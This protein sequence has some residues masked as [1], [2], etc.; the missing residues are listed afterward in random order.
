MDPAPSCGWDRLSDFP[1]N[2]VNL[3]NPSLG[4]RIS[5]GEH[6]TAV[7]AALAAQATQ[8]ASLPAGTGHCPT[9][10]ASSKLLVHPEN[11]GKVRNP[12]SKPPGISQGPRS[13]LPGAAQE[14]QEATAEQALAIQASTEE[15]AALVQPETHGK[16]RNSASGTTGIAQGPRTHVPGAAQ[17]AQA[18]VAEQ[19][20]Q[21]ARAAKADQ[22][23]CAAQAA[24]EVRT[25]QPSGTS[26]GPRDQLAVAAQEA[27]EAEQAASAA[28]AAL[29]MC[30]AARTAKADQVE[31]TARAAQE[32]RALKPSGTSEGPRYQLA[33]AA[34]ETIEAE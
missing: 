34:Q 31:S 9:M 23:E 24:Q 10:K 5:S 15:Q 8:A 25:A 19:V 13:Y 21:A 3:L 1:T 28:Q 18:A 6:P 12:A 11:H 7:Q 17:E 32:V 14:A 22:A 4:S 30:Q 16:L 20:A 26:E 33:V 29:D 27:T 2:G